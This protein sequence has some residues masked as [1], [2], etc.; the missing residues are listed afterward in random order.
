MGERDKAGNSVKY[1]LGR[2]LDWDGD[3][4]IFGKA[5]N[6]WTQQRLAY[7]QQIAKNNEQIQKLLGL[8][9]AKQ[10]SAEQWAEIQDVLDKAALQY[11]LGDETAAKA[12]IDGSL[13]GDAA[14]AKEFTGVQKELNSIDEAVD[15]LNHTIKELELTVP[16]ELQRL[17]MDSRVAGYQNLA[18]AAEARANAYGAESVRAAQAY[19][20]QAIAA[21]KA[22]RELLN[23]KPNTEVVIQVPSGKSAFTA[24]EV[25]NT[26]NA[27]D[28]KVDGVSVRLS[29]FERMKNGPLSI[30]RN[31]R[32]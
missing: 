30:A 2:V 20:N 21:E 1:G 5:N 14:R 29:F 10:F 23:N 6:A 16:Y 27:I 9:D 4:K 17:D 31:L 26:I 22:G 12:L 15:S 13:L 28:E 8:E 32:S 19:T 25:E 7:D 11:K 18:K 24:D 3:G